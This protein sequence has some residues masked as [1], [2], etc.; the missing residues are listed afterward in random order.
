MFLYR[1]YVYRWF[2]LNDEMSKMNKIEE[3][4]FLL[5]KEVYKKAS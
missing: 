3:R 4:V 5:E 1:N 2:K